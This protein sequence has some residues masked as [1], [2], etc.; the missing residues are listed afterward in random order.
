ILPRHG[1][2]VGEGHRHCLNRPVSPCFASKGLIYPMYHSSLTEREMLAY[3]PA[4]P[5][6]RAPTG[7][8][9]SPTGEYWRQT[10]DGQII[11]GG[12]R[13]LDVGFATTA[14]T[15][16]DEVQAAVERVLPGLFPELDLPPVTSRWAGA[17][18]RTPDQMPLAGPV[19]DVPGAW[20]AVGCN[21]HGLAFAAFLGHAL[22]QAVI[23]RHAPDALEPFS[24][25]RPTLNGPVHPFAE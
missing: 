7:G 23:D 8:S 14:Q 6:F 11:I 1:G 25:T 3:A 18:A 20:F 17:M 2:L 13:D 4:A 10:A 12:R 5:L 15:P 22:A 21:G 16:T 24:P 19:P 9:V